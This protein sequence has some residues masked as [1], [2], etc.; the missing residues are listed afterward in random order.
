MFWFYYFETSYASHPKNAPRQ[1]GIIPGNT[2]Q[3]PPGCVIKME[4][5]ES[6]KW[7]PEFY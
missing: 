3:S 2:L 7:H 5:H 6:P 1:T 4:G